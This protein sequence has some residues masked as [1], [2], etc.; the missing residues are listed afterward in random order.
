[1]S[2]AVFYLSPPAV[3]A[4]ASP[5]RDALFYIPLRVVSGLYSRTGVTPNRDLRNLRS[6][7]PSASVPIADKD[8]RINQQ[9]YSFLN[10]FVNV[11]TDFNSAITVSD[12]AQQIEI[13]QAM[14]TATRAEQAAMAQQANANAQVIASL[15]EVSQSADLAGA[16]QIPPPQMTP[17][18]PAYNNP[19]DGGAG[20]AGSSAD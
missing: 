8:G 16:A 12:L 18:E 11:Y 20:G 10:Y 1:V 13:D 14:A 4:S 17:A 15:R 9:W 19:S 2:D 6:Y 3:F 7:L 5:A